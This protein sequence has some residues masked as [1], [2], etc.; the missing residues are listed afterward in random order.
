[1][2][3]S[4]RLPDTLNIHIENLPFRMSKTDYDFK[5]NPKDLIFQNKC[6]RT[7]WQLATVITYVATFSLTFALGFAA[8]PYFT[9]HSAYA[10]AAAHA[11]GL[12][13]GIPV[14]R[15]GIGPLFWDKINTLNL[16]IPFLQKVSEKSSQNGNGNYF[17][18]YY[19]VME[20]YVIEKLKEIVPDKNLDA[21]KKINYAFGLATLYDIFGQLK[22]DSSILSDGKIRGKFTPLQSLDKLNETNKTICSVKFDD[23]QEEERYTIE[24]LFSTCE[25]LQS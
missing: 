19:D 1:M 23:S 22:F 2:T 14:W 25:N 21:K 18:A 6:Y 20:N 4:S 7:L 12:G 8:A 3:A 15:I 5:Q 13:I 11:P 10:I 17:N 9:T 24:D 16:E